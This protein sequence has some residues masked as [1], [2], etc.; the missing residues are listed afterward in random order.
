MPMGTMCTNDIRAS[1]ASR[2]GALQRGFTLVETIVFLLVMVVGVVG[3]ISAINSAVRHSAD[4]L[5]QKQALAIAEALMEEITSA[6]FTF[7]VPG[8]EK[9]ESATSA[10]AVQCG[11]AAHVEG[12]GPESGEARPF[13]NVNDYVDNFGEEKCLPNDSESLSI[14]GVATPVPG[15]YT[16]CIV[17]SED[18]LGVIADSESLRISLTVTGP[19]DTSVALDSYRM[20]HAPRASP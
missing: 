10:D 17:I 9:F 15:G 14:P 6:G 13:D 18:G 11:A 7:C 4:P 19:G 5:A 2:G 16:A 8:T 12:V 20:R 1:L 3:L